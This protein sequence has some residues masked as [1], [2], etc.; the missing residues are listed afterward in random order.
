MINELMRKCNEDNTSNFDDNVS[1]PNSDF[2]YVDCDDGFDSDDASRSSMSSSSGC[3][4]LPSCFTG[5]AGSTIIAGG[6]SIASE[7]STYGGSGG[8]SSPLSPSEWSDNAENNVLDDDGSDYASIYADSVA[9]NCSEVGWIDSN[10]DVPNPIDYDSGG[11]SFSSA[12]LSLDE[13]IAAG[14]VSYDDEFSSLSAVCSSPD[15]VLDSAGG[16]TLL[17][18]AALFDCQV[19]SNHSR[20]SELAARGGATADDG[21]GLFWALPAERVELPGWRGTRGRN[22]NNNVNFKRNVE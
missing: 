2:D 13:G 1:E 14:V 20:W 10:A 6:G 4:L 12:V 22:N 19:V 9:D 18:L 3:C 17:L 15:V 5:H 16:S 11:V 7:G 21:H 8:V